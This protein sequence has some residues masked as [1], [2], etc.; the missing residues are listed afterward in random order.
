MDDR[1]AANNGRN[2]GLLNPYNSHQNII[3]TQ[4]LQKYMIPPSS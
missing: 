2:L 3:P 1:K 4:S